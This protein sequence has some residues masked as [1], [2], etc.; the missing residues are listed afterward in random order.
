MNLHSAIA[1]AGL[2]LVFC[3]YLVIIMFRSLQPI[4]YV[5]SRYRFERRRLDL[6]I[7]WSCFVGPGYEDGCPV[8]LSVFILAQ[9]QWVNSIEVVAEESIE[10]VES[11]LRRSSRYVEG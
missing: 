3:G 9:S 2:R 1:I 6:A 5:Q 8:H 7:R 11:V 4:S 10:S